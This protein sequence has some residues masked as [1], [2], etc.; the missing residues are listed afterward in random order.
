LVRGGS[1]AC[2]VRE[3]CTRASCSNH[4]REDSG[5]LVVGSRTA[6]FLHRSGLRSETVEPRPQRSPLLPS[7]RL[8]ATCQSHPRG[9]SPTPWEL[10]QNDKAPGLQRAEEESANSTGQV[11]PPT[12]ECLIYAVATR[13]GFAFLQLFGLA[14]PLSR[15]FVTTIRHS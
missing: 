11:P 8:S 13:G 5:V 14:L 2:R 10:F 3:V 9:P 4:L 12:T 6:S 1:T 15:G 7:H